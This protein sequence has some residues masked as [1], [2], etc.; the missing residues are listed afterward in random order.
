MNKYL[1]YYLLVLVALSWVFNSFA[2]ITLSH[3]VGNTPIDTGMFSCEGDET[4]MRIFN[5]ADF[6]VGPNE[7][8]AITSGQIAFAES[9]SGANLQ[10]RFYRVGPEFPNYPYSLYPTD[11]LGTRGIGEAPTITGAPEIVQTDFDE[12]VIIPAGTE[13]ILVAVEKYWGIYEEESSVVR[14]AGTQ[15]DNDVSYYYGCDESYSLIPTTDLPNPQPNANFFIN[16]TG[17]AYDVYSNGPE[18]R[19]SHNT[20]GD[21]IR[22]NIFSCSSSFLYWSRTFTL[23]DF[24]ISTNEEYVITKGQV[25]ISGVGW[26]PEINFRIYEIDENFP[27]SFSEDN[28]IG[29]SQYQTLSPAITDHPEVVEVEFD[30]PITVPAGVER[31][32]VEVHKGIVYGDA[33]A[34]VGGTTVDNDVSWQRGCIVNATPVN[35]FVTATEM[36]FPN[37]N[38]YINVTGNV[39]HVSNT[40]GISVTNICSEF[41]KEFSIESNPNINSVL[42]DFGDPASGPDNTSSDLSPFHDFT[43]D[44]TYTIS[45]TVTSLDGSVE[46]LTETIEVNEPPNAY[47]INNIYACEDTLNSGISSSFDI[48]TIETQV[49][50]GQTGKTVTYIDG[51]GNTYDTLPNPFTNT[52]SGLET[53]TVRVANANNPCCVSETTFDLITYPLPELQ[54]VPALASCDNGSNG[55]SQFDL[56]SLPNAI[57]NGQPNLTLELF[58]SS[59]NLIA[60][61]DYN[62]FANVVANQDYVTARATNTTTNCTS[63]ITIELFVSENPVANSLSLINGCDDNNDGISEYFD[64]STVESQ[65]LNGQ[66][67]MTVSYFD[68]NGN[69]LPSPLPNPYTNSTPFSETITVRVSNA[70]STCYAETTL[71]FQTVNQPNINQPNNLYACDTG[72]GFALFNTSNIE[73]ELIGNQTGL[74]ISY[75]DANYNALTSPLPTLFENTEPYAQTINVRVE[76]SA[77]PLCYSETS[78]DLIVNSLPEIILEDQYYICNLEP[79]ITLNIASGYDAYNWVFEDGTSISTTSSAEIIEEGN[80][81]VTVTEISNGLSCTSSFNFSLVRSVLPEIQSVNFGELG[82][83]F[84]E[85][86]ASGDGDFEYSIDGQFFQDSNYFP[87][88]QGGIYTVVVRDKEGCGEDAEEVVIVDYPKFFTPNNDGFNDYWQIKGIANYPNSSTLVYDRYGKLIALIS[89]NDTGWDGLYNGKKMKSSDY[90]FTTDLGDGRSFSGHFALKR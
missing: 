48:T 23:A 8:F 65:V 6:G 60:F 29:S 51:S 24:G 25:A 15:E 31:I 53:I 69:P 26:L 21:I 77:N 84:I 89:S 3:N 4:W 70:A 80:Y 42:W 72:N 66:T 85:I 33:L 27:A 79:S 37:S 64:T 35:G 50:G 18:T 45:A 16:I 59:D 28:L 61:N 19:L 75:F 34:F 82:N 58:D 54:T 87:N 83:N 2:Q 62:N 81:E 5:L 10:F 46:V 57:I 40:Y 41:L 30:T 32:L 71:E 88:I 1:K 74:T 44:G 47:G 73:Q 20:C 17:E 78:F 49:L 86:I 39:N 36:G 11:L 9:Y 7:E 63:E 14:I 90:W 22:T 55:F 76:D 13:Q 68:A 43:V 67:G 56:T 38:F 12:P 52:V